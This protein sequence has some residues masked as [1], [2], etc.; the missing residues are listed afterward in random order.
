MENNLDVIQ[1]VDLSGYHPLLLEGVALD[2][3][4]FLYNTYIK[5]LKE[6]TINGQLQMN[7]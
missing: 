6:E 4:L 3:R 2:V 7:F 1:T 5:N